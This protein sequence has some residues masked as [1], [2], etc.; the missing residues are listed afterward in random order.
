MSAFLIW[1]AEISNS[2]SEVHS[3]VTVNDGAGNTKCS[4]S[5]DPRI[6]PIS[7]TGWWVSSMTKNTRMNL[8]LPFTPGMF[9]IRN[10]NFCINIEGERCW[11]GNGR[12]GDWVW[13][14]SSMFFSQWAPYP[15]FRNASLK[16]FLNS[17]R[18][19]WIL[20]CKK[21]TR[22]WSQTV[23]LGHSKMMCSEE[24][25]LQ[26]YHL[27]SS[28]SSLLASFYLFLFSFLRLL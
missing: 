16:S 21:W 22:R 11:W 5:T 14:W 8:C 20:Y 6:L 1:Q 13:E 7:V 28:S 12:P 25:P 4:V 3:Y 26:A 17:L 18:G 27:L 2:E 10:M 24:I 15:R 23:L 9:F 19:L